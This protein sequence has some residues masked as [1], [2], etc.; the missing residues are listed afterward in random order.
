MKNLVLLSSL[1]LI[2]LCCKT[3]NEQIS[4]QKNHTKFNLSKADFVILKYDRNWYW[5]FKEAKVASLNQNELDEIESII[6]LAQKERNKHEKQR[7]EEAN[8]ELPNDQR[9]KTGYEIELAGKK[10]QYIS[11]LNPKG[12]KEVWIN[13]FCNDFDSDYWKKFP[14]EVS[15]GGNCYL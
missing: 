10:R 13:F 4:K 7:L 9:T 12:E 11:V 1:I 15:D 6:L 2:L 8:K 3:S 14:I 5:I